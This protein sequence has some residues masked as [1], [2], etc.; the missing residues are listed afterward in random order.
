MNP[1][2][3]KSEH[4]IV[5]GSQNHDTVFNRYPYTKD[6]NIVIYKEISPSIIGG[7]ST[8]LSLFLDYK[9]L[10]GS[11]SISGGISFLQSII[12]IITD[13]NVA[14][15]TIDD[16]QR[17]IN[18]SLDTYTRQQAETRMDSIT[19]DYNQYL[20]NLRDYINGR[21]SRNDFVQSLRNNEQRL[22]NE[23]DSFFSLNGRELLLLPNF[24]QVA[25]LHL[26]I[27]RDAVVYRGPDLERP[28]INET[29]QTPFLT[30][31]PSVSFQEALL[32]SIRIYSN[33]CTQEYHNGLN[34]MRNRGNSG[35][36]WL[37]F[38]AYRRELTISVLDFVAVF[39]FFNITRY[40][41][42]G[43]VS[44]PVTSQLSRVIYTD[45]AGFLNANG[46]E[47]WYAP[48]HNNTVTFS[49]IEN[50]IPAPTTSRFLQ[51]IDI[52]TNGL[53]VG[54]NPTRTHSWQGNINSNL[55]GSRD[56]FGTNNGQPRVIPGQNIF[57]INST[58]HTLDLRSFGLSGADF[59]H[60]NGQTSQY[61]V[62]PFPPSGVGVHHG[63]LPQFLPGRNANVPTA[64]DFTHL[65]SRIA[66]ITAG[67]QPVVQGQ[68]NSV[69]IHG[70][71]H[72]DLTRE[73]IYNLDTH[74]LIPAVK[75]TSGIQVISGPGFTGGDL[76]RL[77]VSNTVTYNFRPNTL[78]PN[79]VQ[80]RIYYASAGNSTIRVELID[81]FSA[82]TPI[83]STLFSTT[84][85]L[86]NLRYENFDM[87]NYVFGH[88]TVRMQGNIVIRITNVGGN[89]NLLLDKIEIIPFS[90]NALSSKKVKGFFNELYN[91]GYSNNYIQNSNCIYHQEY[92]T[93]NQN[94]ENTYDQSYDN[95]NPETNNYNQNSGCTCNEDKSSL[96]RRSKVESD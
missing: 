1:Y 64:N 72:R 16:V 43:N 48:R 32:T 93:Y 37:N 38:N 54:V 42:F 56:H 8:L 23:L 63:T 74:F 14:T 10:L 31:P 4:E 13:T 46:R 59:L 68:R 95:Y 29:T 21:A 47:G 87:S 22:R 20:L 81:P 77:N 5:G 6:R 26:S 58:V 50:N 30:R 41:T 88:S 75:T 79:L 67:L 25:L 7:L 53:G 11:P 52:F 69:V 91:P 83:T 36:D 60:T 78:S 86:D 57:R 40:F 73:N 51:N 45:P 62:S 61:R 76:V 9:S 85:S 90:A 34:Q 80:L 12:G 89:S 19:S 92:N 35:R 82:N 18:Q 39:P 71:T 2:Q 28:F 17:L 96:P 3:N 70:W 94:M 49:S 15:V 33:Y 27:L 24:V 55:D 84:T 44:L 66:N 65:L